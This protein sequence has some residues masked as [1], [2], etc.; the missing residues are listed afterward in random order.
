VVTGTRDVPIE[1]IGALTVRWLGGALLLEHPGGDVLLEAPPGVDAALAHVGALRGLRAVVLA[2]GRMR[3][4]GGLL[5]VLDAVSRARGRTVPVHVVHP[6]DVERAAV[7]ADAWTRGWPEGVAVELDAVVPGH[8][9]P[10]AGLEVTFAPLAMADAVGDRVV[11]VT[12]SGVRVELDGVVLA[13]APVARPGA[14]LRRLCEG[15]DL[16]V[17]EV[18]RR[19]WPEGAEGWRVDVHGADEAAR[20]ARSR[21]RVGDDGVLVGDELDA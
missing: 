20:T 16:A 3:S 8:P 13:W 15:A 9:V 17:V 11:P 14:A 21:W 19:P 1:R 12:G 18:G 7:V 5:G 2:T 4:V 10:V 6:V